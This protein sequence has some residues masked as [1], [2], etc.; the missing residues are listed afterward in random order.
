M[1]GDVTAGMTGGVTAG[2]TGGG[3]LGRG[4]ATDAL[5]RSVRAVSAELD[6]DATLQ[7]IVETATELTDAR[8]GALDVA[9]APSSTPPT[10]DELV[11][12]LRGRR[13]TYGRIRVT[14]K[15]DGSAFDDDDR[16][17]LAAFAAAAGVAVDNAALYDSVRRRQR[18]LEAV[19]EITTRLLDGAAAHQILGIIATRTRELTAADSA[20]IVLPDD[21][22]TRDHDGTPTTLT[23]AV[24]DGLGAAYL[25][26][27]VVPVAGST[28]GAVFL[29]RV[30]RNVVHLDHAKPERTGVTFG[31]ALVLPL[32][33]GASS[34]GVL[35][36]ARRAGA[37]PFDDSELQ[38][39]ASFADQAA[40]AIQREE[41]R[42]AYTELAVLSDRHRIARDLHDHV[43]QH[44]FAVGLAMH[45]TRRRS[46]AADEVADRLAA[47]IEQLQGVIRDI[48]ST[49]FELNSENPTL[50]GPFDPRPGP[51]Y[52][53]DAALGSRG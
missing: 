5:L 6:L 50:A 21:H 22:A 45:G 51:S 44:L 42:K 26:G 48:R 41:A 2:M 40:L 19:E 18:W 13:R 49:I 34:S 23:V 12:V 37:T 16:A 1:T 35:V 43:I 33:T 17:V 24:S 4:T 53:V 14:G 38:I 25:N 31:P 46:T 32:G 39:A 9:T 15:T 10:A 28:S 27:S 30:P 29:D 47:H 7:R 8:L 52:S 11:V 36:V 3:R 20:F